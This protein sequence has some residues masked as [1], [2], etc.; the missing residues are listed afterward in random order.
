M[1][2]PFKILKKDWRDGKVP[3][4]KKKGTMGSSLDGVKKKT[5][6]QRNDVM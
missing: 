3:E 4:N 5:T 1:N 2:A 6:V